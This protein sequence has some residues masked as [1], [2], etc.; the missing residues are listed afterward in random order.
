MENEVINMLGLISLVV[1]TVLI[2]MD[3]N[4][5]ERLKTKKEIRNFNIRYLILAIF[6]LLFIVFP[7]IKDMLQFYS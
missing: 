5:A 2:Y 6:I 3:L 7:P 1:I 4:N